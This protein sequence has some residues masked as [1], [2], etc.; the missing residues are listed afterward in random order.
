MLLLSGCAGS[1]SPR[2]TLHASPAPPT[3]SPLFTGSPYPPHSIPIGSASAA[4]RAL[5]RSYGVT[6]I[7]GADTFGNLP[8]VPV[9]NATG[10]VLTDGEVQ[11]VSQAVLHADALNVWADANIQP[12][13]NAHLFGE[14]FVLGELG[15]ALAE[16][17]AV[18]IPRCGAY[19]Y[20]MVVFAPSNALQHE[21]ISQGVLVEASDVPVE[22]DFAGNCIVTGTTAQGKTV[23]LQDMQ[24]SASYLVEGALHADRVL[25]PIYVSEF[26]VDC[27]SDPVARTMCR[28]P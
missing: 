9:V 6:L 12:A 5:W 11:I 22:M 13:M 8:A 17:T 3:P 16:G 26:A 15:M 21:G 1:A 20:R 27:H 24:Q 10:G 25:G 7:P 18:H 14:Q 28:L 2:H 23:V 4:L 19:P